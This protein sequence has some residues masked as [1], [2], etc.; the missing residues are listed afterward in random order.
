MP[1]QQPPRSGVYRMAESAVGDL[2]EYLASERERGISHRAIAAK[3]CA[4][5]IPVP[6]ETVRRWA[7]RLGIK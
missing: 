4:Q 1:A 5:G 7:L 3:L 6:K 2:S